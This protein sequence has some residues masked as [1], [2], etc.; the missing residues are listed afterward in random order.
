MG[1]GENIQA[2]RLTRGCTIET[3]CADA[4]LSTT[5]LNDIESGELDPPASTVERLGSALGVPTAWLYYHPKEFDLLLR[6]P[7][8]D[9][10]AEPPPDVPDPITERILSAAR[11]HRELYVLLTALLEKGDEKQIRAAEL[12]L[13]SLL[14]QARQAAVPWQSRP[15]GHFEPPSD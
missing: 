2:W 4:S 6:D 1:L 14:K 10:E 7:D 5:M 3:L 8:S 12:S 11:A 9:G 15:P 13:R